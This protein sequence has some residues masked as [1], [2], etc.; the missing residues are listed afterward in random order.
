MRFV[1]TLSD[2]YTPGLLAL[3]QSLRENAEIPVTLT[4]VC[5]GRVTAA[6]R[7]QVDHVA[8]KPC[9]CEPIPVEWFPRSQLGTFPAPPN[10]T[11][12]MRPNFNKPLIWRLPYREPLCY[13]DSDI[14]CLRSLAGLETWDELS[15]VRKQTTIG[16]RP[17]AD[18]TY[19]PSGK[20]PWNAGVF[21]FRPSET[22]LAGIMQQA[23]EYTAPIKYGDQVILN[24]FF[25]RRQPG[26]VQYRPLEWNMSTWVAA[27]HPELFRT[28][29]TRLLHFA[30]EAKPWSHPPQFAWQKRFW[31]LWQGFHARAGRSV[32]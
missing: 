28:T 19:Q 1:T 25:N 6:H 10:R 20:H 31:E 17:D 7:R 24:D 5:Y 26:R 15:V 30:H 23:R 11:P 14:L 2:D 8:S 29:K 3:I 16:R 22:T 27:K 18:P 12:R 21:V 13:I 32:F 4:V 9:R